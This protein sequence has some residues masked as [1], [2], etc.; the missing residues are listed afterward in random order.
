MAVRKEYYCKDCGYNNNGW[1]PKKK[2][3]GL[4]DITANNCNDKILEQ[5]IDEIEIELEDDI[6]DIAK[7]SKVIES[8]EDQK[9]LDI[10]KNHLHLE[11]ESRTGLIPGSKIVTIT[12]MI[13]D[14][15]ISDIDFLTR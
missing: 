14:E 9:I 1:C 8:V 11:S 6:L 10:L 7:K 5:N 4:K 15:P 2:K 3:N 12:L 13:D